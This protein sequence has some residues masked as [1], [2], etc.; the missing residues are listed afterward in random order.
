MRQIEVDIMVG[1]TP[2]AAV[3]LAAE[4]I[5]IALLPI[6]GVQ[7]DRIV[8]AQPRFSLSSIDAGAY[9]TV[10]VRAQLLVI[11]TLPDDLVFAITRALWDPRNRK[12]L[13]A[14]PIGLQ[15]RRDRALD[16][17]SVPLHAGARRYY[18]ESKTT[19]PGER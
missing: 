5:P 4:T 14:I 12:L 2:V 1:G 11:A 6:D 8:A 9:A 7:A 19:T 3:A 13:D 17:L 15:I 16:N 10:A 18:A